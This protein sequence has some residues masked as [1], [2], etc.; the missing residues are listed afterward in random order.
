MLALGM[1]WGYLA[2][3]LDEGLAFAFVAGSSA[4]RRHRPRSSDTAI[5]SAAFVNAMWVEGY[6]NHTPASALGA[7]NIFNHGDIRQNASN[8]PSV[9]PL[10]FQ[11]LGGQVSGVSIGN[12]VEAGGS[13]HLRA[14]QARSGLG[15]NPWS[16]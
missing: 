7:G 12:H 16:I 1:H 3:D 5:V 6:R 14:G 8:G 13:G 4:A 2:D 10:V 11:R 9:G 15:R